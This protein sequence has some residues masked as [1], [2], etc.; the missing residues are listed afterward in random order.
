MSVLF[1]PSLPAGSRAGGVAD[2]SRVAPD[3]DSRRF[4][5]C[6][7]RPHGERDAPDGEDE[8]GRRGL[9]VARAAACLERLDG[10]LGAAA[11]AL[12]WRLTSG[13]F[14]GLVV[15]ARLQQQVLTITLI[16]ANPD[17]RALAARY[18]TRIEAACAARFAG[19]TVVTWLDATDPA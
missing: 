14:A 12:S 17:Q 5:A 16:P 10:R 15:Q 3:T 9:F 11:E 8:V 1:K 13:R 18:R 6:L 7:A 4:A 19:S 2:S